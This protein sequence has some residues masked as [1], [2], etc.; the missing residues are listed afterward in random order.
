MR[1]TA[2]NRSGK[3]A[4]AHP[5]PGLIEFGRILH[6]QIERAGEFHPGDFQLQRALNLHLAALR[7]DLTI[8]WIKQQLA[9]G[10]R[11]HEVAFQNLEWRTS[12]GGVF[13]LGRLAEDSHQLLAALVDIALVRVLVGKGQLLA[14]IKSHGVGAFP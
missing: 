6:R 1:V 12:F 5:T 11:D 13:D 2:V 8:H 3:F 4:L 7:N 9:V 14:G 10:R